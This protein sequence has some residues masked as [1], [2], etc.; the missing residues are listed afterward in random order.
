MLSTLVLSILRFS[1]NSICGRRSRDKNKRQKFSRDRN[2]AVGGDT[3]K[4]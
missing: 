4:M 1:K 2:S 3:R